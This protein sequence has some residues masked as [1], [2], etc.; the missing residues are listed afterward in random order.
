[1]RGEG[2]DGE[3]DSD[4]F[5]RKQANCTVEERTRWRRMI[6][7]HVT[8]L[9]PK[10]GSDRMMGKRERGCRV[11]VSVLLTS[12]LYHRKIGKHVNAVEASRVLVQVSS[13]DVSWYAGTCGSYF[14][15][16]SVDIVVIEC[17]WF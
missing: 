1:M 2:D 9:T 6:R 13:R 11:K 16:S 7:G 17:P 5:E 10:S 4:A 8:I 15:S 12:R 14:F 3:K